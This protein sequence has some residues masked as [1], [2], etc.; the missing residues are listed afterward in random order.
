MI[1]RNI[2]SVIG[3][4]SKGARIMGFNKDY[5]EWDEQLPSKEVDPE[6]PDQ[7]NQVKN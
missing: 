2:I 4:G 7:P 6:I 5:K 3:M 1:D